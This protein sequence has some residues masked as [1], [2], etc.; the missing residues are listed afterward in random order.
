MLNLCVSLSLCLIYSCSCIFANKWYQSLVLVICVLGFPVS[1]RMSM[2]MKYDLSL[3]G[4][5]T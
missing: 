1:A 4:F 2:I 5:D 3:L